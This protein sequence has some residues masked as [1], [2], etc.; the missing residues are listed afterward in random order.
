MDQ[1]IRKKLLFVFA[2]LLGMC[3]YSQ[4]NDAIKIWPGAVPGENG[5]KHEP[6]VTPDTSRNITRLTDITDP[7]LIVFKP[8][9]AKNNGCG[10]IIC[11]GGGYSILA[12]D[13][14]G[15]EVATWLNQLGYTAF[16]LQYRVP[17]KKSGALSDLQRALRIIRSNSDKWKLDPAKLGVM[18]FSAGGSLAARASTR[19][20]VTEYAKIDQI[21]SVSCRPDFALLIYPAYLDAGQNRSLT[22]ELTVTD[23]TP[24]M[25]IFVAADDS[26]A[27]SSLVMT[28][29]LQNAKVPVELH[30]LPFGGH[31]F[32]IR[33]GNVAAET[34]PTYAETWL[35]NI[36]N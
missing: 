9:E 31:G 21:D 16:V 17:G 15:Y 2:L 24:P 25:F 36:I 4:S 10:I 12:I 35:K 22:P 34:W 7:A 29:A 30:V 32:G 13:L 26:H 5:P 14:E 33:K 20:D 11:P 27:N 6:V 18:G 19:F 1:N 3:C 23:N 8:D 28:T